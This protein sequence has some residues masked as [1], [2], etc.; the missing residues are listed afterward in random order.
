MGDYN[1]AFAVADFDQLYRLNLGRLYALLDLPAPPELAEPIAQGRAD[2]EL[3]GTM[4]RA[5]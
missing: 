1:P 3:G 5:S 2:A 4:R